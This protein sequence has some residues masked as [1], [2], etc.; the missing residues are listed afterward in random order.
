MESLIPVCFIFIL[1]LWLCFFK[2]PLT[3]NIKTEVWDLFPFC[4]YGNCTTGVPKFSTLPLFGA[5]GAA[6]N[7]QDHLV[8]KCKRLSISQGDPPYPQLG[9]SIII[10]VILPLCTII[11]RI[12]LL[13]DSSE[14]AAYSLDCLGFATLGKF[15]LTPGFG[16][17]QI[18][19]KF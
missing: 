7:D 9:G 10:L 15:H 14:P 5:E 3:F 13:E 4:F 2:V 12:A 16:V 17:G 1:E 19:F 8:T 18:C 6:E 11:C